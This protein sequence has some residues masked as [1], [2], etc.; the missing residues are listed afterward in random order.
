[1]FILPSTSNS[2]PPVLPLHRR[3]SLTIHYLPLPTLTVILLLTFCAGLIGDLGLT[4]SCNIG[5]G[6][7]AL[8]EAVHGSVPDIAGKPTIRNGEIPNKFRFDP[9]ITNWTRNYRT[10]LDEKSQF[11]PSSVKFHPIN[12]FNANLQSLSMKL[13]NKLEG[14]LTPSHH[15]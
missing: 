6:G 9:Q 1:M 8:A 3:P 14:N 2:P 4:S 13:Q 15:L 5:E 10:K 7:I 12:K 11:W